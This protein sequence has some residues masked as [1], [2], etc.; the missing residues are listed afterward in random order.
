[1]FVK[2]HSHTSSM[3][4]Y[5]EIM[6]LSNN[7]FDLNMVIRAQLRLWWHYGGSVWARKS[8]EDNNFIL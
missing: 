5:F 4:I 2:D 8:D 7:C 6:Y 3:Y 1:M